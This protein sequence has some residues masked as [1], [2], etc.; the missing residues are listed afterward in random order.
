MIP[1]QRETTSC[2]ENLKASPEV[3]ATDLEEASGVTEAVL[4][5]QELHAEEV[6]NE[7]VNLDAVGSLE[8]QRK[9]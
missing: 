8:D 5:L 6:P 2:P 7:E 9:D 3:E 1:C 4:E